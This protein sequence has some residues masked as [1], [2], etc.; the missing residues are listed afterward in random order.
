MSG[1][2]QFTHFDASNF[3]TQFACELKD[4]KLQILLTENRL[5]KWIGFASIAVVVADEAYQ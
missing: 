5:E 2:D 4:F 3:K 1:R